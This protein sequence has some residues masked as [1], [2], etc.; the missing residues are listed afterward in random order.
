MEPWAEPSPTL[1][2]AGFDPLLL[3]MFEGSRRARSPGF[4]Q[5]QASIPTCVEFWEWVLYDESFDLTQATPHIG[6]LSA[7]PLFKHPLTKTSTSDIA[8]GGA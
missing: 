7:Q 2:D 4:R 1:W 6:D 3:T 8:A 5:Q